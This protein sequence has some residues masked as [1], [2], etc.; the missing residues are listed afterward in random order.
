MMAI[1]DVLDFLPE[2]HPDRNAIIKTLQDLSKALLKVEDQKTGLWYQVMDMGDREGNYLEGSGSAMFIY[3][4]AK[5][6]K[7]GYLDQEYLDIASTKFD[8]LV[9]TLIKE[10]DD[11][12]PLFSNICGGCGL[13]GKPYREADYDYYINEKKVDNDSKGVAP[14][15]L[16]ALELD[17]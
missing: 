12:Y 11:G 17:K 8:S 13:G 6:A 1:V 7:M 9:K 4:F 2:D 10:G 5:G 3:A 16:A 14:M 15:I